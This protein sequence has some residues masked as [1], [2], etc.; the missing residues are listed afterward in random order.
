MTKSN[1]F[2]LMFHVSDPAAARDF[3]RGIFGADVLSEDYLPNGDAYI[4]ININGCNILL[5]PGEITADSAEGATGVGCCAK[6]DNESDL[7]VAY[8][9]L[10]EGVTQHS[11]HD[12]WG[13]TRLAAQVTDKYGVAWLLSV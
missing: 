4:M 11:L 2:Y 10:C 3:Y 12:D 13:W 7:R 8:A 5:R 1:F 9:A 6:F